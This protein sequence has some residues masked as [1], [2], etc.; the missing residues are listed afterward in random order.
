MRVL[1]HSSVEGFFREIL[2]ESLGRYGLEPREHTEHYLVNL[3]GQYANARITDEPLSLKMVQQGDAGERVQALK[4]VGDT[5]LYITG[6]FARSME[7]KLVQADYYM[8]LGSA[9]YR[10]LASRLSGSSA[11]AVYEELAAG[12]SRFV[13]VLS[14]LRARIHLGGSDVVGLYEEWLRSRSDWIEERLRSLGV[15]VQGNSSGLLQ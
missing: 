9:A 5:S 11:R 3:L 10:E 8:S 2:L 4:E 14:D 1:A 6:F 7:H 12:F 15:M 13:E